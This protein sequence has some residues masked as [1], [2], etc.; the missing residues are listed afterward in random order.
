M[1]YC[2]DHCGHECR[3]SACVHAIERKERYIH[4]SIFDTLNTMTFN[5]LIWGLYNRCMFC[6]YKSYGFCFYDFMKLLQRNGRKFLFFFVGVCNY[7]VLVEL[8]DFSA[9]IYACMFWEMFENEFLGVF[10]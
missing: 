10:V 3:V 2:Y 6:V 1:Y 8:L 4:S 5:M 9:S 7:I